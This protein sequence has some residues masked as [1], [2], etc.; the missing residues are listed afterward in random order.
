MVGGEVSNF[1]CISSKPPIINKKR[2]AIFD[3]YLCAE[4][5]SDE[6]C[7]ERLLDIART[8]V[9]GKDILLLPPLLAADFL[10]LMKT[11]TYTLGEDKT[12]RYKYY[13][14]RTCG[15]HGVENRWE[16]KYKK[17][18]GYDDMH[19]LYQSS[20]DAQHAQH[21]EASLI[22]QLKF[23]EDDKWCENKRKGSVGNHSRSSPFIVYLARR[24]IVLKK[25]KTLDD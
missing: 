19:L 22:E 8:L 21:V 23:V 24:K 12:I 15:P 20:T 9:K 13:I 25:L 3:D 16:D 1:P 2:D 17:K 7:M 5:E 18:D 10:P 4:E 6:E 14:G 11:H